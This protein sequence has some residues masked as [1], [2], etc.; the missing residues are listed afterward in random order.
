MYAKITNGVIDQFPYTVADLR[1]ENPATS[2]P[3]KMSHDDL[4]EWGVYFVEVLDAP[5]HDELTQNLNQNS[6]PTLVDGVWTLGW[7]VTDKTQA[8]ID[9]VN[10]NVASLNRERRNALLART[11]WWA[12]SDLTMTSE[13]TLY[14]TQL[15]DITTHSNWPHLNE[16]DWPTKP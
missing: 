2:F 3:K 10:E 5:S 16:D 8:D 6:T 1:R 7:T 4:E 11:D 15:R 14:R 12:S 9:A 13:Q